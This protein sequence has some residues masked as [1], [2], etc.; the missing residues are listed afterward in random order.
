MDHFAL[1]GILVQKSDLP[2]IYQRYEAFVQSWGITEPLH[3]T[4][5]RGKRGHFRWL[6]TD[7]DRADRFLSELG[8]LILSLNV[9]GVACVI[10]RPGYNGRYAALYGKDRWSM[11]RTAYSILIERAAKHARRVGAILEV[12]YEEAGKAE[13]RAVEDYAKSLKLNGMPFH[14]DRSGSYDALTS[15]NFRQ[16]VLGD[17]QRLKKK[18]PLVQIADLYLYP[19]AKSGYDPNYEPFV[20]MRSA[21]RI[22]DEHIPTEERPSH[23]IKYSCF[24]YAS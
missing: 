15:E 5:I 18:S 8:K 17:P 7:T 14:G 13:D 9:V 21:K 10:D 11:C 2:D 20:Q 1:G 19:M 22:I 23:G 3:S 24:G 6:R 12:F 4:K 16:I